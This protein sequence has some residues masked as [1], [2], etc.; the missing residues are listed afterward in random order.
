MLAAVTAPLELGSGSRHSGRE[1]RALWRGLFRFDTVDTVDLIGHLSGGTF[2]IHRIASGKLGIDLFD[3]VGVV[4]EL[5]VLPPDS[6][7][8]ETDMTGSI[9]WLLVNRAGWCRRLHRSESDPDW[10]ERAAFTKST[11]GGSS[12]ST[13]GLDFQKALI[14][15]EV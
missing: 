9:P 6:P 12:I 2:H 8:S 14:T 7:H 10:P 5:V 1:R 11:N 3:E 4:L 15:G 13:L